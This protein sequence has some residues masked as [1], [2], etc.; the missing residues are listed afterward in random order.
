MIPLLL[1]FTKDLKTSAIALYA[2]LL[3]KAILAFFFYRYQLIPSKALWDDF[4]FLYLPNQLP[5]FMLGI[6]LYYYLTEEV[7]N[8]STLIFAIVLPII[9]FNRISV[10]YID[11]GLAMW[12]LLFAGMA[13]VLFA[14]L[15]QNPIVGILAYIGKISY[16]MYLVHFAVLYWLG[17]YSFLDFIPLN[18]E[19]LAIANFALRYLLV[20]AI[21]II[22]SSITYNMIEKPMIKVGNAIVKKRE[23][24]NFVGAEAKP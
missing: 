5:V 6:V 8:G 18:S 7:H 1:R 12:G 23:S 10:P 24:K 9:L 20:C 14:Y 16:S 15:R 2:S 17:K 21:T 3:I 13:V 4:L 22:I 11:V 19:V